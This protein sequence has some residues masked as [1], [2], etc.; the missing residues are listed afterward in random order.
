MV[1]MAPGL[2]RSKEYVRTFADPFILSEF[3]AK[4]KHLLQK[5]LFFPGEPL[6]FFQLLPE[7][8]D[9]GREIL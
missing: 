3:A 9:F 2:A 4:V 7:G 5:S 8:I 1:W 6:S